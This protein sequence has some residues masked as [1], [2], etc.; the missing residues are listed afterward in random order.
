[1]NDARVML[2]TGARKGIG[3]YLADYYCQKG[4]LVEGCSRQ[5]PDWRLQGYTHHCVDVT[6]EPQVQ[7]M[8][9]AIR[10]RHNRLDVTINNAGIASM[11]HFML[12][13]EKAASQIMAV[14]MIGT[15][16]ICRESAKLMQARRWGRI[17]NFST[18]A[19]PML[20]EGEA[21]YAAS[22]GAIVT[23]TK[24]I[25]REVAPLGITCNV[26][27]PT[28]IATDL[29]KAVPE[30]KIADILQRLCF[31]RLGTFEDVA[32]VIDFFIKPESDNITGQLVYLGG[33][34]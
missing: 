23:F 33:V 7:Q 32:N 25:A 11:N 34:S 27:G 3:R 28:P 26:V 15:F 14:N 19:V 1:M 18:I 31:R 24:I 17:V 4:F 6:H 9:A 29:I 30:Q 13:P 2:I 8:M 10:K 12:T 22:K 16:L 20:L 5:E 21:L